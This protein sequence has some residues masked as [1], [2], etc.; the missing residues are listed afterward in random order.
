MPLPGESG[1]PRRVNRP[2]MLRA[3]GVPADSACVN[4]LPLLEGWAGR[5]G[6]GRGLR[7]GST[8]RPTS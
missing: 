6:G 1:F 4:K 2:E 7:P 8:P 5:L 3:E